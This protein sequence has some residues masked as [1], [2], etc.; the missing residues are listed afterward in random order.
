MLRELNGSMAPRPHVPLVQ[1]QLAING[2]DALEDESEE[3]TFDVK[4]E[5]GLGGML[6]KLYVCLY[7][8][9]HVCVYMYVGMCE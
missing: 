3:V 6:L 5:T 8:H 4:T 9:S 7:V 1:T 2:T